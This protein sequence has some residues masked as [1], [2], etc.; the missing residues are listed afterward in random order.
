MSKH[1]FNYHGHTYL[2]GHAGGTPV[3][4]VKEAI[5]HGYKTIG[6]SE[7]APMPNLNSK[8]S[9]LEIANYDL[10]F[11]I[12]K[13]GE[14]LAS[15]HN[16]KFLKGFEIEYFED[17][18][19]YERYLKDV[20]YL[21]LGQHYIIKNNELKSTFGLEDLEDVTI[22][23]DTVLKALKTGYF[24]LLCHLDLCFFNIKNPT[25]EMYEALRPVVKIAKE[26][27]IPIELNAN[28]IRR[29]YYED[30]CESE[31]CYRY[32]RKKLFQ[33]V[34]E[35]EA[36][37]MITS[38]CHSPKDFHDF[39]IEKAEELIKE[40]GLNEVREIKVNYYNND[41]ENKQ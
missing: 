10:Y 35:E 8:N 13:E 27:N 31:E 29:A 9:R 28:G 14:L 11:E 2:C 36:K 22:Y 34:K 16:I 20:D 37:V 25:D 38:D 1:D 24:S 41:K 15:K 5:K 40:Y 3:D 17:L 26:L 23:R 4:F 30:G 19:V 18:D 7:H 33:I 6:I 32:P 39:A 12:L 21:I